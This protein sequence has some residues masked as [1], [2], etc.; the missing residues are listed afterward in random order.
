VVVLL[1]D[2]DLQALEQIARERALPIGTAA[3]EILAR[4]LTRRRT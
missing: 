4:T 1:T 2:S 3:Y